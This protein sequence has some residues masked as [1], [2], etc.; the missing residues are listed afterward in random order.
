[1]IEKEWQPFLTESARAVSKKKFRLKGTKD[2]IQL[3][4]LGNGSLSMLQQLYFLWDNLVETY[5]S[6][7]GI[8]L[9]RK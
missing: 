2:S 7:Y 5:F 6:S 3:E 9:Q 8:V 1:V 4:K